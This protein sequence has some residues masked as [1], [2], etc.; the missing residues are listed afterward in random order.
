MGGKLAGELA[1]GNETESQLFCIVRAATL[2]STIS[3]TDSGLAC[4]FPHAVALGEKYFGGASGSL[5]AAKSP[6]A[7]SQVTTSKALTPSQVPNGRFVKLANLGRKALYTI[8]L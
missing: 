5:D 3:Q 7:K 2:M 4:S 8:R 1:V 6:S